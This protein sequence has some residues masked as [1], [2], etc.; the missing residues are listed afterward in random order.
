MSVIL[1]KSFEN[2]MKQIT[3]EAN[4]AIKAHLIDMQIMWVSNYRCPIT[5]SSNWIPVIGHP[6]EGMPIMW[7][8]VTWRTNHDQEFYYRYDLIYN[9]G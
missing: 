2:R 7:Q 8:I 5:K 1:F 3:K 4:N 9:T 6:Y